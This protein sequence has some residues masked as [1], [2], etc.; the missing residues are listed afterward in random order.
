LHIPLITTH[1][2]LTGLNTGEY[3]HLTN[4]QKNNIINESSINQN[5]YLSSTNF[6]IFNNKQ[7]LISQ[8]TAFNKNYENSTTNIK[9]NNIVSVGILDTIARSDHIHPIDTS[10]EPTITI[11][12]VGQYFR[13]DKTFQTLDKSTVGLSNVDNTTD[14]NKPISTATQTALNLK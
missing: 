9:M 11:G 4:T 3:Q 12:T 2:Q 6:T 8:N 10:R 7:N 14:L 5:G 13:G 1:D